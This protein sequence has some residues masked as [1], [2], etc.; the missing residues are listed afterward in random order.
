MRLQPNERI[1]V[2]DGPLAGRHGVLVRLIDP[3]RAVVRVAT[4]RRHVLVELE[5]DMIAR[6][7]GLGREAK[8]LK[9]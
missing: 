5:R 6:P 9:N 7:R 4:G 1:E 2:V 8:A 3:D